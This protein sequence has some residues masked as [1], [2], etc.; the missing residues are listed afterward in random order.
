MDD[1][2]ERME[3]MKKAGVEYADAKAKRVQLEHFRKSKKAILMKKS[4]SK[5]AAM[6]EADAYSHKDYIEICDGIAE[7]I[8]VEEKARWA[9]KCFEMDFERWRTMQANERYLNSKV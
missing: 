6:A 8:Q 4:N 7:A 2:V 3:K 9:L 1:Y 5:T